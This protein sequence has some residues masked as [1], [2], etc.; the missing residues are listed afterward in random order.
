MRVHITQFWKE[1]SQL[2]MVHLPPTPDFKFDHRKW[3]SIMEEFDNQKV[4]A[5][6]WTETIENPRIMRNILPQLRE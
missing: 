1:Y 4:T 6:H 3:F 5:T 2:T